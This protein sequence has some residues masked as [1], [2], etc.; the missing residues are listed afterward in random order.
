[1]IAPEKI[2]EVERLLNA[3]AWSQRRIAKMV[4][5]SRAVVGAI[6]AGS[7][8]DYEARRLARQD[9]AHEPLGPK[10][11]CP[12]CGAMVYL[13]CLGCK[14]RSLKEAEREAARESRRRER[15]AAVR[16]LLWVLRDPP[17]RHKEPAWRPLPRRV[18]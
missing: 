12:S 13:P 10:G 18:G 2:V 5:I 11:R 7:R 14:V 15:A 17:A 4:G 3:G 1:M 8:P 6:A 9:E 16:Q